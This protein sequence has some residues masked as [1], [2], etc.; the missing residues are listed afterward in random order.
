MCRL[1]PTPTISNYLEK[2]RFIF[3]PGS[4]KVLL[5]TLLLLEIRNYYNTEDTLGFVTRSPFNHQE[6]GIRG[7]T[8]SKLYRTHLVGR[9]T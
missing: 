9:P 7:S 5:L 8:G 2:S 6:A 1:P 4:A 3:V